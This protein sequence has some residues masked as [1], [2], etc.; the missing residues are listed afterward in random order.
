MKN[1]RKI[2]RELSAYLDGELTPSGCANVEEHL[3]TCAQC[4]QELSEM[5]TLATGLAA[6]PNLRP[7]PRFL[8]EVRRKIVRGEKPEPLTWRDY[9][10]RPLWLKVPLEMA[11]LILII[12]M[13]LRG[14][15]SEPTEEVTQFKPGRVDVVENKRVE[16]V[17]SE[18]AATLAMV[19][20]LKATV[21]DRAPAAEPSQGSPM[22]SEAKAEASSSHEALQKPENSI[23]TTETPGP[24]FAGDNK[25]FVEQSAANGAVVAGADDQQADGARSTPALH[26][27]AE[28]SS[29][30]PESSPLP[31]VGTI[32][33]MEF[34]QSKPGETV[35]VH[36][37]DFADVQDQARRLAAR[38]NGRIIAVPQ[39]KDPTAQT[40]FVEL[41]REYV[42][43]FK[44]ELLKVPGSPAMLAKGGNANES[45]STSVGLPTG[46]LTGNAVTN[47]RVNAPPPLGLRE[48]AVTTTSTTV[49]EIRVVAPSN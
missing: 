28:L 49:L 8:T 26:R 47:N 40:F 46:V 15:H 9:A 24:T 10:F 22:A 17:S 19:D 20:T 41:P 44:L 38:C 27:N 31:A 13:V 45:G 35:T 4:Q 33:T 21:A 12:V 37:R 14:Q 36:A 42:A 5:K 32:R 1:C 16:D 2:Q 29:A 11:A 34:A 7:A 43:A 3:A 30:A 23:S 39:S 48:D 25:Q 6:L 18:T